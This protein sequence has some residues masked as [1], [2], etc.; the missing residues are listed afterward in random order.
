[1]SARF[2]WK[3][4]RERFI[5]S[6]STLAEIGREFGVSEASMRLR[7]AKEQWFAAREQYRD[8][9]VIP[10][11][12]QVPESA[13][14]ILTPKE[15]EIEIEREPNGTFFDYLYASCIQRIQ[16]IDRLL[17]RN[18]RRYE[19]ENVPLRPQ[20]LVALGR[21]NFEIARYISAAEA[22]IEKTKGKN[23]ADIS[24][25]ELEKAIQELGR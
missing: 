8:S 9:G 5:R 3:Q 18:L 16:I 4:I 2:P 6:N 20:D 15:P 25:E 14:D 19:D 23:L 17:D 21:M 10:P 1:M 7:S 13:P 12:F 24:D 22:W 11:L